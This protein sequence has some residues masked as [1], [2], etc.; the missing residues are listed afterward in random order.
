MP[1]VK[2]WIHLVFGTKNRA[3]FLTKDIKEKVIAHIKENSFI[4][5][6]F[7]DSI[8]GYHDHLHCLISLG[9][10][11]NIS[12]VVNLIKG[13][14]SYWINKNKITATKF[15]WAD[16]Y[17]AVSVSES[18]ID[19]IRHYINKQEDHH[20][21]KSFSEEYNEFINKFG[22]DSLQDSAPY[23]KS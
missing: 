12:K 18:Q 2:I 15:E 19:S 11:Q 8:N 4:K 20:R 17:F 23:E 14:S 9:S 6:I 21:T 22:F 7:I 3:P 1:F 10:E 13:E 5:N 16:E